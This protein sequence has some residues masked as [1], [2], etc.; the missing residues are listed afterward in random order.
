M[1][2]L[3]AIILTG[4]L[5][6]TLSGCFKRDNL[7]DIKIY[8]TVYP[9]EYITN[10][11]YGNH[12]EVFSIYPNGVNPNDYTLTEKQIIDYSKASLFI[13]NG[14]GKE[15]DYVI[16]MFKH[17]KKLKI[18]DT[19]LTME[20]TNEVEEL[21]LDPSNFLML[22]Q[23]IR[24]GLQEYINNHYLKE[25]IENEYEKLRVEISNID[26]KLKLITNSTDNKTIVV[27]NDL[28]KFLEK[29][30]FNV[31]SLEEN[32]NL[33]EKTIADVKSLI[34]N[35]KINYIFLKQNEEANNTIKSIQKET[36][37]QLV[38]LHSLSNLSETER[39]ENEDYITLMNENIELL[40]NELY[41]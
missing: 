38:T 28:Y 39:K 6:I 34:R 20:Y 1:K 14:C 17:N 23:N 30:N 24:N 26:A 5:L 9:V 40:K 25:D 11:L 4:V 12:S 10:R 2:K 33:T 16:P 15:K 37:I 36:G 13:F 19:A 8:T 41:D 3:G 29:Y 18:I 7:E 21:W 35:G 31:I 27:A 32:D 22:S